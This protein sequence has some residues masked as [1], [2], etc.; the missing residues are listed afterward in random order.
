MFTALEQARASVQDAAAGYYSQ[1]RIALSDG[2]SPK[3]LSQLMA[4]C[5]QEE[6]DV[7]IRFFEVPGVARGSLR[8]GIR[9]TGAR[10][11]GWGLRGYAPDCCDRLRKSVP[12]STLAVRRPFVTKARTA[13]TT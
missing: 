9:A 5:R 10:L 13:R 12:S 7:A 3:R 4:L 6:P 2:L 8:R 1:L 11:D